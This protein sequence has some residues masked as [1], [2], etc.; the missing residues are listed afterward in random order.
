MVPDSQ[1]H[2]NRLMNLSTF[3]E[4]IMDFQAKWFTFFYDWLVLVPKWLLVLASGS[5]ASVLISFMHKSP[6][7][8]PT[9]A[10]KPAAKSITS[11]PPTSATSTKLTKAKPASKAA[12]PAP[13]TDSEREASAA[14]TKRTSTR[15]RKAAKH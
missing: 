15:Q 10:A 4:W 5:L 2:I 12:T 6:P 7:A 3:R 8:T 9:P 11:A 14:P 1:Q 13:T